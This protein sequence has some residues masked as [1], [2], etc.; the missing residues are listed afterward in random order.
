MIILQMSLDSDFNF[1]QFTCDRNFSWWTKTKLFNK[2]ME[3]L[4]SSTQAI[5]YLPW[6]HSQAHPVTNS[7]SPFQALIV[8]KA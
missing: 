1:L 6:N 7:L 5:D 8:S 3:V 2:W 4:N